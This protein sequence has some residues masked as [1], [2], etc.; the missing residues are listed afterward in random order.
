MRALILIAIAIRFATNLQGF[1]DYLYFVGRDVFE[2]VALYVLSKQTKGALSALC[3]Y[4]IWLCVWNILKPLFFDVT[5]HD[6][7]EYIGVAIGLIYIYVKGFYIR[8]KS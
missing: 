7:F 4:C 5:K 6:Y 8:Q 3:E 1:S 2:A